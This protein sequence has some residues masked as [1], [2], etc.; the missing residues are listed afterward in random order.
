M[1]VQPPAARDNTRAT[2]RATR[3]VG[4]WGHA[5][6]A[7]AFEVLEVSGWKAAERRFAEHGIKDSTV[8]SWRRAKN[9]PRTAEHRTALETLG[10]DPAT[11]GALGAYAT[12]PALLEPP[13]WGMVRD[14][15][16][17]D[18]L[19]P[20]PLRAPGGHPR[21]WPRLAALD[22]WLARESNETADEAGGPVRVLPE[23]RRA[24]LVE[25]GRVA[26]RWRDAW[27]ERPTGDTWA[28]RFRPRELP[29]P[30]TSL[31]AAFVWL[32]A[33]EPE[34]LAAHWRAIA[35]APV[36]ARTELARAAFA[37]WR[38]AA[39]LGECAIEDLGDAFALRARPAGAPGIAQLIDENAEVDA[40]AAVPAV[41]GW[42]WLA[43]HT[44]GQVWRDRDDWHRRGWS[45]A[46]LWLAWPLGGDGAAVFD[47]TG[48][49]RA[50]A[51]A[52]AVAALERTDCTRERTALVVAD[53]LPAPDLLAALAAPVV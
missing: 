40:D 13:A 43:H 46:A 9:G 3:V 28:G 12:R 24:W 26:T 1:P 42:R 23:A 45:A 25:V 48:C 33:A 27:Q 37:W 10:F 6:E 30:G 34:Q 5:F 32:V 29:Q 22:A 35:Y 19:A 21:V 7:C 31:A 38:H 11:G 52:A 17:E 36:G 51:V 41:E 14:P 18:P 47:V 39:P 53:L 20:V 50:P 49:A 44:P 16:A 15:E 8:R 2:S 4:A